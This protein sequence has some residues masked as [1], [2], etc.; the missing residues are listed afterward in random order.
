MGLMRRDGVVAE[1]QQPSKTL[2]TVTANWEGFV[3]HLRTKAQKRNYK[4]ICLLFPTK[5]C[6]Q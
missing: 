4:V 1:L 6:E 2:F 5:Q 3:Q